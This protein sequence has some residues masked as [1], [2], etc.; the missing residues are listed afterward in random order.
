MAPS[1]SVRKQ[2]K[3]TAAIMVGFMSQA[4][5]NSSSVDALLWKGSPKA[6]KVQRV[7]IAIW[8]LTFLSLGAFF[9]FVL[10]S[11]Q[12]PLMVAIIGLLGLAATATTGMSQIAIPERPDSKVVDWME[13]VTDD[14]YFKGR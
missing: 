1:I 5:F 3:L 2:A 7:G 9:L 13:H 4:S 12:H 8:G 10:A 14:E 6:T 11:E